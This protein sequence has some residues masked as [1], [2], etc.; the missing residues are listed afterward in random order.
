MYR[1]AVFDVST[2]EVLYSRDFDFEDQAYMYG[3]E[4]IALSANTFEPTGYYVEAL[5]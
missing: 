4:E 3:E 1:T 5:E 2:C